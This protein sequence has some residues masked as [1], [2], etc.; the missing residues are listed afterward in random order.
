MGNSA[1]H[2]AMLYC[3]LSVHEIM[4]TGE[5][6]GDTIAPE[7]LQKSGLDETFCPLG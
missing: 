6:S 1:P 4:K 7:D 3:Q 2:R 5:C